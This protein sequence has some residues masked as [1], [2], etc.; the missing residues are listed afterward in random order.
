MARS[1]FNAAARGF[2]ACL[3]VFLSTAAWG[4]TP[5]PATTTFRTY[6]Q[7]VLLDLIVR[8]KR[9][10]AVKDLKPEE[11]EILENNT[12]RQLRSLRLVEGWNVTD[13]TAAGRAESQELDPLR[14]LRLVVLALDRLSPDGRR[15]ARDAAKELFSKPLERNVYYMVVQLDPVMRIVRPFTNDRVLLRWAVDQ[16]TGGAATSYTAET[17][18]EQAAEPAQQAMQRIVRAIEQATE[19]MSRDQQGSQSVYGLL[20]LVSGLRVI[21]GRKTVLY[22]AE[23]LELPASIQPVYQSLLGTANRT[24]T[25]FYSIDARGLTTR[26]DSGGGMPVLLSPD[27]DGTGNP[28]TPRTQLPAD[29]PAQAVRSNSQNNLLNLAESTGGLLLANSND[30]RGSLQRI[31]EDVYAYYLASY[32]PEDTT[33]DGKFRPIAVRLKRPGLTVQ[34]RNGYIALPPEVQAILL[35]HEVP[36]FKAL[37]ATPLPKQVDYRAAAFRFRPGEGDDHSMVQCAFHIEVP[38]E[39]VA[40]RK[41]EAAKT[42]E[43]RVAFLVLMKDPQGVIKRKISRDVPYSGPLDKLDQFRQGNI[44]YNEYF[45]LAPGRY[46]MESALVDRVG[47]KLSAKRQVFLLA[48]QPPGVAISTLTLVR[49]VEPAGLQEGTAEARAVK[50]NDPF[51][52]PGGKIIPALT[53][54]IKGGSGATLAVYFSVFLH[55]NSTE[56]PLLSLEIVA[57]GKQTAQAQP[58][59]PDADATGRIPFLATLPLDTLSPGTYQLVA[60]VRQGQTVAREMLGFEVE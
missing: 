52:F 11:L 43:A 13:Q 46:V 17:S 40:I 6:A 10:R 37:S 5:P 56:K 51:R 14:Q 39:N 30:F 4:Q 27:P 48:A 29:A 23:G 54:G 28:P 47:E 49:R 36:L 58:A 60:T 2:T 1:C 3:S 42:F 59:L 32:L 55:Q 35:S 16:A 24:N 31:K 20:S 21:E 50:A 25:S 41:N 8:D 44:A 7:E 26:M 33:W 22:F 45:P 15:I 34:T 9:G 12:P 38:M 19:E 57:D 53:T 18:R